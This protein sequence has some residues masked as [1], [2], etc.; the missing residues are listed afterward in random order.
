MA[1]NIYLR[2]VSANDT[3]ALAAIE[4]E[5]FPDPSW[6]PQDFVRYDCMVAEVEASGGSRE[7]GGFLVSHE[8]ASGSLE[9]PPQREILNIAVRTQFRRLGI[10]KQLLGHE[11]RRGA[12]VFLEVRESNSRAIQLYENAG[13]A[14]IGTRAN[15]YDNPVESAIVMGAKWC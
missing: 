14:K 4:M 11:L 10:A 3:E 5:C 12:E 15:Y 6:N 1:V 13:F 7:I 8:I 9:T 2:P